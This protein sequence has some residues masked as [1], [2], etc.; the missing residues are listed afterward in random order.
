LRL[1]ATL[2]AMTAALAGSPANAVEPAAHAQPGPDCAAARP[3]AGQAFDGVVLHVFDD[4]SFCLAQG[5]TPDDWISVRLPDGPVDRRTMMAAA[6][7]QRVSC[8][9]VATR[10]AQVTAACTLSGVDLRTL[11]AD[12]EVAQ[13]ASA[14]R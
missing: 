13:R 2:I 11:T 6:F 9:A 14:W 1:L 7:A 12:P 4:G 8:L 5:P 10:G 3:S